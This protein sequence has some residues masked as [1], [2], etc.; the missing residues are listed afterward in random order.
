MKVLL[1]FSTFSG[2]NLKTER[3]STSLWQKQRWLFGKDNKLPLWKSLQ[4]P[5]WTRFSSEPLTVLFPLSGP[6]CPNA[7]TVGTWPSTPR[8]RRSPSKGEAALQF[9]PFTSNRLGS[10]AAP[11]PTQSSPVPSATTPLWD[12][13]RPTTLETSPSITV[14]SGVQTLMMTHR[15]IRTVFTE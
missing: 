1:C 7:F 11:N 10:P 2:V 12:S 6:S 9:I 5:F 15:V 4:G 14:P 13:Q 3:I 8:E